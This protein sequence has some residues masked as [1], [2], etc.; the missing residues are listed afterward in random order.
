EGLS[1]VGGTIERRLRHVKN[2]GIPR[3][4]KDA[5]EVCTAEHARV[6]RGLLPSGSA[7]VGAEE[8]LRQNRVQTAAIGSGSNRNAQSSPTLLR[9]PFAHQRIRSEER[10]V[11]K[12]CR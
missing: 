12:E 1:A 8:P 5:A 3:V 10:R 2:V 7:I 4:N 6:L 9:Q 11:G